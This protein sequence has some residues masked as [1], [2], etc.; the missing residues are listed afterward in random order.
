MYY[1]CNDYRR[2]RGYKSDISQRRAY[3]SECKQVV[4]LSKKGYNRYK[5]KPNSDFY[6]D[7]CITKIRNNHGKKK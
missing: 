7:E 5:Y 6:C 2:D 4:K 1:E 3:C